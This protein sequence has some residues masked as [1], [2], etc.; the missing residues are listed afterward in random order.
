M[1]FY[2]N[3]PIRDAENWIA[4]QERKLELLPKCCC[5]GE[6]IQTEEAICVN[7]EWYCEECELDAWEVVRDHYLT[8]V[9]VDE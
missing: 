9:G 3:D 8:L 2:S 5:C 4:A 7:D 1:L 6:P